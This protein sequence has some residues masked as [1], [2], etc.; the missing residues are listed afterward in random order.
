MEVRYIVV[1][2]SDTPNGRHHDAADIRRWHTSPDPNDPSKP[3]SDIGYHHVILID[4]TVEMGRPLNTPGAHAYGYNQESI[5]ICLIGRDEF[6]EAQMRSLEGLVI[7]HKSNHRQ[8]DVVGHY[9]LDNKGKTCPNFNVMEW[10]S[11]VR[12]RGSSL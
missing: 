5:G 12:M 1:H 3:W 10:W 6:T 7:A 2:C 4:G 9:D 8:A 11:D